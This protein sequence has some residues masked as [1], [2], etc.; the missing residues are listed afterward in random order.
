[1]IM[2]L[3]IKLKSE[4][5][6]AGEGADS[7]IDLIHM[8]VSPSYGKREDASYLANKMP[9]FRVV[10]SKL[11]IVTMNTFPM[12]TRSVVC[13]QI[14]RC[15]SRAATLGLMGLCDG[16][17]RLDDIDSLK[18]SAQRSCN[19]RP[20]ASLLGFSRMRY[21]FLEFFGHFCE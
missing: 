16:G 8:S 4:E 10:P 11:L 17:Q 5:H 19:G 1:M 15:E 13:D 12:G 6:K 3:P 2:I 18:S 7:P 9:L 21:D 14:L 20:S